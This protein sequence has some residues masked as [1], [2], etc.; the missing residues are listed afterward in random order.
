M[1]FRGTLPIDI[2]DRDFRDKDERE[3]FFY[4]K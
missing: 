1:S 2:K 3:K 4:L